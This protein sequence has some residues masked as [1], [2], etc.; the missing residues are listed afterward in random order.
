MLAANW[1]RPEWGQGLSVCLAGKNEEQTGRG[2]LQRVSSPEFYRTL[3]ASTAS[4]GITLFR[5]FIFSLIQSHLFQDPICKQ[6]QWV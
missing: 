6:Q 4:D 1:Y 2:E 5:I 3:H